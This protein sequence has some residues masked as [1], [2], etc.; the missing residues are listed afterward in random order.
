MNVAKL[1]SKLR[2]NNGFIQMNYISFF[3]FLLMVAIETIFSPDESCLSE[4]IICSNTHCETDETGTV[5]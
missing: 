4:Y 3:S 1:S 5:S 2:N